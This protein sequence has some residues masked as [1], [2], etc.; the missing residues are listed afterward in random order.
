M[1]GKEVKKNIGFPL[2]VVSHRDKSQIHSGYRL[3]HQYYQCPQQVCMTKTGQINRSDND[4]EALLLEE[5]AFMNFPK[6]GR[7]QLPK[8]SWVV[9]LQALVTEAKITCIL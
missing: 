9:L 7:L 3:H 4:T 8:L 2:L 5:V 1:R 6:C